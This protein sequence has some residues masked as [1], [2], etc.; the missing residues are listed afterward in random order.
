MVKSN[1]GLVWWQSF[2]AGATALA[3]AGVMQDWVSQRLSALFL[4]MISALHVAT[5]VYV[6]STKPVETPPATLEAKG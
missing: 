6:A 1:N 2:M 5:G 3:G 4:A